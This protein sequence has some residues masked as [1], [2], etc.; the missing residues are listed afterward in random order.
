MLNTIEV[1]ID[2]QG[3][4]HPVE[5]IEQLPVGRGLLTLLPAVKK[6]SVFASVA[7]KKISDLFGLL[8]S[9]QGVS[10]E[11]MADIVKQKAKASFY[12]SH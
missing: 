4:V 10:A 6:D 5:F 1:E 9:K 12:D 11:A 2:S 3:N 8:Q 7:G